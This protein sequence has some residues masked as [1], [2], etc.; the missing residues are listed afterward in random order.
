M[1]RYEYDLPHAANICMLGYVWTRII[2]KARHSLGFLGEYEY[3]LEVIEDLLK[4]VR[5]R[6]GRRGAWYDRQVLLLTRYLKDP[7]RAKKAAEEG[8]RDMFT[9]S[10]TPQRILPL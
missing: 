7:G 4:Q 1:V 3:E 6:R 5:W 8:L 9:H 2:C 10:S